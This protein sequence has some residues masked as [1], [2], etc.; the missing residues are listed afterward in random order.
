MKCKRATNSSWDI[1]LEQLIP[2]SLYRIV[3]PF[4]NNSS[5]HS[6]TLRAYAKSLSILMSIL[7]VC[8]ASLFSNQ[9]GIQLLC[10]QKISYGRKRMLQDGPK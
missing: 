6:L 9:P 5:G 2:F 8:T 4:R 7:I 10:K 3:F 1:H